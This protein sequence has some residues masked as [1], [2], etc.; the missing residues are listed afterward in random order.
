MDGMVLSMDNQCQH[1]T[2]GF[3]WNM[4]VQQ[5][6]IRNNLERISP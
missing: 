3:W 2:I 6:K 5:Q 4:K 1:Q